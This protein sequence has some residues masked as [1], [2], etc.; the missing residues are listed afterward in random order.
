MVSATMK[1]MYG[2]IC[3]GCGKEVNGSGGMGNHGRYD[4]SCTPEMRFWGRVDKN[5]PNGCWLYTGAKGHYGYGMVGRRGTHPARA[6]RFAWELLKGTIP[7]GLD[8]LHKCDNPPCCNPDHMWVGT[9][10]ENMLDC[11]AKGRIW[12]GGNKQSQTYYRELAKRGAK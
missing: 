4:K 7:A 10:H 5:G 8:L 1:G 9:H 12:K 6:H 2:T 11:A 3:S